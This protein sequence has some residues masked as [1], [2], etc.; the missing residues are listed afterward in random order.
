MGLDHTEGMFDPR[1]GPSTST[2]DASRLE[3]WGSVGE[4]H[5]FLHSPNRRFEVTRGSLGRHP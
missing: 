5:C 4:G 2:R 1:D 3:K